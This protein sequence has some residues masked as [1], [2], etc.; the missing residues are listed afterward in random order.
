MPSY[1]LHANATVLCFHAAK[2][3]AVSC[4]TRVKVTGQPAVKMTDTFVVSGCPFTLPT[5][6]PKPQ[7]CIKVQ[8][9]RAASKVLIEGQPA[10][11]Q[12]SNGLCLSAEQIPQ[13]APNVVVT[14]TRVRGI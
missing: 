11:L 9:I 2:V 4:S 10:L 1:L 3:N 8:W 14:Q 13:G 6:P 12:D 5:T 7:P